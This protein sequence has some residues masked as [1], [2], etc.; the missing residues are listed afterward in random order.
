MIE[1]IGHARKIEEAYPIIIMFPIE[2]AFSGG[3]WRRQNQAATICYWRF[4][5]L[6]KKV[7]AISVFGKWKVG[8][9]IKGPFDFSFF[10]FSQ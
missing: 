4:H 2:E 9:H 7:I 6:G 1:L 8:M 3:G 5:N 10:L